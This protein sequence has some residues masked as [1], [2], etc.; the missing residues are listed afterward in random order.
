MQSGIINCNCRAVRYIPM[1]YFVPGSLYLFFQK[2]FIGDAWVFLVTF[3]FCPQLQVF[4]ANTEAV[5]N[6]LLLVKLLGFLSEGMWS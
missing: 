6:D 3:K 1:T 4:V 2:T 5:S